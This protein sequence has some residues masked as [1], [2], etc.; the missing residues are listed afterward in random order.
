MVRKCDICGCVIHKTMPNYRVEFCGW[1]YTERKD[2]C[3]SCFKRIREEI[4][5]A[6]TPQTETYGVEQTDD[7]VKTPRKSRD[8][9]EIADTPHSEDIGDC[10]ICRFAGCSECD[11]CI[12]GSEW[13]RETVLDDL[14]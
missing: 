1:L 6:D 11:D 7:L 4:K 5:Q 2:I 10:N 9:H 3:V 13:V 8:C 12:N 14:D